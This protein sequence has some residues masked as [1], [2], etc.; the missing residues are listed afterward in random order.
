M[1][2]ATPSPPPTMRLPR[3]RL[4]EF[5]PLGHLETVISGRYGDDTS[6]TGEWMRELIRS[7][8]G[9]LLTLDHQGWHSGT[10]QLRQAAALR[11]P[12]RVQR[13]GKCQT[14][15]SRHL[16]RAPS[17]RTSPRRAAT[18]HNRQPRRAPRLTAYGLDHRSQ[19]VIEVRGRR[20]HLAAG[21]DPRLVEQDDRPPDG[22]HARRERL[23]ITRV[24]PLAGPMTEDQHPA[25]RG[26]QEV[27]R[28][29]G[30]ARGFDG[31]L[32]GLTRRAGPDRLRR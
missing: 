29:T 8:E 16:R 32:I 9:I 20:G 22:G 25:R 24:D 3:T 23:K 26:G 1:S 5:C 15:G 28:T 21:H 10:L 30:S 27:R 4:V 18:H 19:S 14:A 17:R 13:K 2:S 12:G 7:A 11:S 31:D 6:P